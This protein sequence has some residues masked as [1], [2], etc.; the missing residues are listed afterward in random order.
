MT[1]NN[2]IF[3]NRRFNTAFLSNRVHMFKGTNFEQVKIGLFGNAVKC[4]KVS[5]ELWYSLKYVCKIL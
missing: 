4:A 5:E 1:I 2:A 3:G